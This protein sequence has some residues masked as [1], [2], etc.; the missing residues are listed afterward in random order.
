MQTSQAKHPHPVAI[1]LIFG[2]LFLG[3]ALLLGKTHALSDSGLSSAVIEKH[4]KV[5]GSLHGGTYQFQFKRP[6]LETTV[7]G[8]KLTPEF[9]LTAWMTISGTRDHALLLGDLPLRQEEVGPVLRAILDQNLTATSLHNR[10]TMDSSRVMSLHFEGTGS[11]ELMARAMGWVY[12]TLNGERIKERKEKKRD[13]ARLNAVPADIS[14]SQLN[15]NTMESLLW[16]G[17]MSNGIFRVELPRSTTLQNQKLG[18]STGA[19]SWAAFAGSDENAVVNG[20]VASLEAELPFVLKDLLEANIQI[21]SIHT[22]MT[23]ETPKLVFVH[24]FGVGKVQDL[25][26][27]VKEAIWEKEHFQSQ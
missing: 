22:H 1:A 9:G 19:S 14:H 12:S 5:K 11:E 16:K 27:A 24:F 10:F 6:N 4:S 21:T 15:H 17:E 23:Q 3:G 8:V 2:F 20:D 25:A 26:I 13:V 7:Q 18:E